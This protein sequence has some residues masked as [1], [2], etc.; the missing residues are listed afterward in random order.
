MTP[1][2]EQLLS[3]VCIIVLTGIAFEGG[4]DLGHEVIRTDKAPS[5]VGPYSQAVLA[6]GFVFVSGQLGIDPSSG[7]LEEGVE[8]QAGRAL[9]NLEAVLSAA[10]LSTRQVVKTTVLLADMADF[11]RVNARYA[12]HFS[13]PYPARAAF[14]VK[15]LPL[16]ALVEIEAVAVNPK[17]GI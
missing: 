2:T 16:G 12:L 10:G 13:E 3:G 4:S 17:D 1:L 6:G 14:A 11:A 9:D 5:P 15:T 7:R 8:A